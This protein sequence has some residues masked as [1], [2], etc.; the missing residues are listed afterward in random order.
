VTG[1]QVASEAMW[2]RW[3][4]GVVSVLVAVWVVV[5]RRLFPASAAGGPDPS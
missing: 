4:V 1:V 2:A 3:I 5:R